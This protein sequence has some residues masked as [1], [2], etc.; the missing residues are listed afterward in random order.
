MKRPEP[1][2]KPMEVARLAQK[3]KDM[4]GKSGQR[5][6]RC[7]DELLDQLDEDTNNPRVVDDAGA[8]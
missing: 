6:D 4:N 8:E 3:I 2:Y 7:L 5:L 1:E